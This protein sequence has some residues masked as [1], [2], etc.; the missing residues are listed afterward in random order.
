MEI[1]KEK[2]EKS[3]KNLI[4]KLDIYGEPLQWYIGINETYQTILCG[5]RAIFVI[6]ISFIFL[7]YSIIN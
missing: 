2:S 6:S 4:K 7:L 5:C 1:K 3:Y